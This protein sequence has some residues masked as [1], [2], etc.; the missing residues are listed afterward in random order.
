MDIKSAIQK[1]NSIDV[2]DLK[3]IDS[4][5]VKDFFRRHLDVVGQAL[6]V[7]VAVIALVWIYS[8][9]QKE[10]RLL[11]EKKA[12]LKKKIDEYNRLRKAKR[13]YKQFAD[14]FP[15]ALRSNELMD[16]ILEV[17]T[18]YDVRISSFSP[19]KETEDDLAKFVGVDVTVSSD[20][21]GN[22]VRFIHKLESLPYSLYVDKWVVDNTAGLTD[23]RRSSH[24]GGW[25]S[26]GK[27]GEAKLREGRVQAELNIISVE[28]KEL[29]DGKKSEGS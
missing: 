11:E 25:S 1:L 19:T 24:R 29:E 22:I 12:S 9:Y 16:K 20:H 3:K 13:S 18:K 10:T 23:G 7:G 21:Y 14:Q 5:Q 28:L 6:L 4:D 27:R 8:R 15:E 26:T 17:A 2:E